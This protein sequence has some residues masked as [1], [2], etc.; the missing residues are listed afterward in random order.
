MAYHAWIIGVISIC[1]QAWMSSTGL[2]LQR[3]ARVEMEKMPKQQSGKQPYSRKL[4]CGMLVYIFSL[5]LNFIAVTMAPIS[6]IGALSACVYII[7]SAIMSWRAGEIFTKTDVLAMAFGLIGCV[8]IVT[9]APKPEAVGE[10]ELQDSLKLI[11][12]WKH[13]KVM[14]MLG[15]VII[16]LCISFR[17]IRN[18]RR[19][20]P[21]EPSVE[22]KGRSPSVAVAYAMVSSTFAVGA[23]CLMKS[24]GIFALQGWEYMREP[25]HFIQFLSALVTLGVIGLCSL[26]SVTMGAQ[27]YDSRFFLPSFL[28]CCNLLSAVYG[29]AIGEFADATFWQTV[30]FLVFCMVA[31]LAIGL[32]SMHTNSTDAPDFIKQVSSDVMVRMEE[33]RHAMSPKRFFKRDSSEGERQSISQRSIIT[34]NLSEETMTAGRNPSFRRMKSPYGST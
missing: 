23:E 20:G 10:K 1:V 27:R 32:G 12:F 7:N 26:V 15:A 4:V 25:A 21:G 3:Q 5:P 29:L 8:G 19:S 33:A 17:I 16:S 31:M 34:A 22:V 30:L 6:V 11:N 2:A 28:A 24:L 18:S 14:I 9:V 13:P